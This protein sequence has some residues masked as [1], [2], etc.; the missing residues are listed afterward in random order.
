MTETKDVAETTIRG[1]GVPPPAREK[2]ARE[3]MIPDA[4]TLQELA[5][6]LSVSADE[7]V[8][9][10]AQDGK[11]A[12]ITDT[13][14]A[15]TAMGLARKLG[16]APK[17][18]AGAGA[19][20][21]GAR[22]PLSL[23]RTVEFGPRPPELQS[24]PIE[25]GRRR[26]APHAQARDAPA[27]LRLPSRRRSPSPWWPSPDRARGPA[28]PRRAAPRHRVP[29]P[30]CRRP[31]P[32]RSAT[33]APKRSPP[34]AF[35]TTPSAMRSGFAWKRLPASRSRLLRRRR[36]PQQHLLRPQPRPRL[37]Q[38]RLRPPRPHAPARRLQAPPGRARPTIRRC[39][40][41]KAASRA[42]SRCP[43]RPR[44]ARWPSRA[45]GVQPSP[46]APRRRR[47]AAEASRA[48][49]SPE[50]ARRPSSRTRSASG[51]S[52]R[53]TTPSTRSSASVRLPRSNAS[54]SARS[55]RPWASRR[56]ARRS[57][58]RW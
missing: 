46:T 23:Q 38:H 27:R 21:A 48:E 39:S 20:A 29:L 31:C 57:C 22:K 36:P 19:A 47:A 2:A 30:R 50:R 11:A 16:F 43:A 33:R 4:I 55:S 6:R 51:S 1:G 12:T 53:S 52:S 54:A 10:L 56:R 18:G 14:D 58:A 7:V 41:A 49:A 45:S 8:D 44:A 24:R 42:R 13:L 17:R 26:E 15:D 37:R 40:R 35:A 34:L 3:V 5:G 28:R 9:A 25:V 32:R